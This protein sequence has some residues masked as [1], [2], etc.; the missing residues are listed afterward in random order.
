MSQRTKTRSEHA[1][2]CDGIESHG[3]ADLDVPALPW[4]VH[5]VNGAADDAYTRIRSSL[6]LGAREGIGGNAPGAHGASVRPADAVRGEARCA[7]APVATATT[8][9]PYAAWET[10]PDAPGLDATVFSSDTMLVPKARVPEQGWQRVV[11]QTSGGRLNPGPS[12]RELAHAE[13]VARV[14][15]PIKGSR[16]IAVI[17][18]KGGVG[19]TTTTLMLG[20]TFATWRGDRVI[21]LDGNPDAGSLGYR[22]RR[23]HGA[24]ITNLLND[25]SAIRRY[26]DIRGYTSQAS[27][28]LEVVASDDDARITQA[29]GK[30]KLASAVRLMDQHYNL[31]LLDTGTGILDSAT[32]GILRMA[33]QIVLVTMPSLDGARAASLTLDWLDQ[34]GYQALV[35]GAV[36]VL[37]QHRERTLVRVDRVEEHFRQRC[38]ATVTVPCDPHLEAGA[39]SELGQ[40][41]EATRDAYLRLAAEVADG[42]HVTARSAAR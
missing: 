36:A 29:I 38:R 31:I 33:D 35:R 4:D 41:R 25:A 1:E 10:A 22:V 34:N 12:A 6:A 32:Q 17:S 26:A 40:L 3:S 27:S 18:R 39:Q 42:F 21:A 23:E 11:Y 16:H 5:G 8:L 14:R 13:L 2:Q 24:T 15:T 20:H 37:N 7:P 28:R 30:G 9:S 19:K